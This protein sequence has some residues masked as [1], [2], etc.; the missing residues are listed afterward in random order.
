MGPDVNE[1]GEAQ[2]VSVLT[3]SQ[4]QFKAVNTSE[5]RMWSPAQLTPGEGATDG[6]PGVLG[7]GKI[8]KFSVPRLSC[9][10]D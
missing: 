4:R 7:E 6:R 9:I 1:G 5:S 3:I 8:S 10:R 2:G